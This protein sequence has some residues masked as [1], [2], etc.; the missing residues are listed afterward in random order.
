MNEFGQLVFEPV[1]SELGGL[2]WPSL[3]CVGLGM[4]IMLRPRLQACRISAV[5]VPDSTWH[6]VPDIRFLTLVW[7]FSVAVLTARALCR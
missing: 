5:Q 3:G 2:H 4:A 6:G 7:S 1:T